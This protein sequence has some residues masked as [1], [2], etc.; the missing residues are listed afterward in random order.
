MK[1]RKLHVLTIYT[2]WVEKIGIDNYYPVCDGDPTHGRPGE[3]TF[4]RQDRGFDS[5]DTWAFGHI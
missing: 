2:K 5:D 3:A 4:G 1:I